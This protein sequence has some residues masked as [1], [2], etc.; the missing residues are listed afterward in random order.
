MAKEEA[1]IG[2]CEVQPRSQ[3][4]S[5]KMGGKSPGDDF[6]LRLRERLGRLCA[7]LHYRTVVGGAG[8]GDEF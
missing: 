2:Y 7:E 3:G 4:F 8:V 6:F 1:I 5:L